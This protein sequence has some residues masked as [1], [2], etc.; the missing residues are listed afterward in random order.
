MCIFNSVCVFLSVMVGVSA[1]LSICDNMSVS[2]CMQLEQSTVG[3]C[4]LCVGLHF[5]PSHSVAVCVE[6]IWAFPAHSGY[7][8]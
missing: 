8:W 1:F 7:D 5:C 2:V 6:H 3:V 4:V